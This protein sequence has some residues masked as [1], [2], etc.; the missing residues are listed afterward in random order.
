MKM[1][2]I[3]SMIRSEQKTEEV[4][5]WVGNVAKARIVGEILKILKGRDTLTVFDFGAGRGGD[6]PKIL[7]LYPRLNLIFY[8]PDDVARR[9]LKK[10]VKGTN[11][12]VLGSDVDEIDVRADVIVS[13]SVFEHVFDRKAYLRKAKESLANDGIFFLNYD[14]GHFRNIFDLRAPETW[15]AAAKGWLKN[16]GAFL[17]PHIDRMGWYQTRVTRSEADFLVREAGFEVRLDRYENLGNFKR[18]SKLIAAE[19]RDEFVKF[20]MAVESQLNKQFIKEVGNE[21]GDTNNL[22]RV[23]ASRTLELVHA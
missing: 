23:M 11:A 16:A 21:M 6:W 22:W 2:E 9:E 3:F 17:W 10:A 4:H 20:W 8:E 7:K 1:E 12:Q 13:F 5:Y 19:Q 18:L 15:W 14:D